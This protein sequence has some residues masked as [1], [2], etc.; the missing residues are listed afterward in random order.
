[1]PF[2][3]IIDRIKDR[4]VHLPSGRIYNTLFNPPKNPVSIVGLD[5][6]T[7]TMEYGQHPYKFR[8]VR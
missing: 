6:T 4:W 8:D 3:V 1:M 5:T 2:Q 7:E